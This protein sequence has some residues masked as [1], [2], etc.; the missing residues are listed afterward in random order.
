MPPRDP[1][2]QR[3]LEVAQENPHLSAKEIA[4]RVGCSRSRVTQVLQR[5]TPMD[6]EP[7]RGRGG[8]MSPTERTE[9]PP[10]SDARGSGW[11]LPIVATL[12]AI[13]LVVG[14]GG[15]D[16]PLVALVVAAILLVVAAT[17]APWG[18]DDDREEGTSQH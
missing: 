6:R 1:T 7:G 10:E 14:L 15:P 13:G 12:A 4:S 8:E 16:A 11:A 17:T 2:A 3:I 5:E 18:S 9:K